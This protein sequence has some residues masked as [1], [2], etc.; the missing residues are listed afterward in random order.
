M[1]NKSST[2]LLSLALIIAISITGALN[3]AL[4]AD[5][6][7]LLKPSISPDVLDNKIKEVEAST[8]LDTS[9]KE[10]LTE[11]YR[12]SLTNLE[13]TRSHQAD[14]DSFSR[15]RENAP[16]ETA[17]LRAVLKEKEKISP[18]KTL[19]ISKNVT[20]EE[21]EQLLQK[22]KA[23]FAAVEAKL[24]DLNK[25]L[26]AQTNRP[27]K[28]RE[29]LIA[30]KRQQEN[31]ITEAKM[32]APEGEAPDV[33][34]ARRW[35]L[36]TQA[37][38]LSAEITMLDRELLS[39]QV[40]L[41]L[42]EVQRE[43]SEQDMRLIQ[44]R[45]R[46]LE[47]MLSQRRLA[48]AR[49]V[50]LE[51]ETLQ[52]KLKGKH[53]LISDLAQKN[54][55]LGESLRVRALELDQVLAQDDKARKDAKRIGDE[56]NTTR[57]KLE[58][59]G[60]NQVLGR[61]LMEQRRAL[62]NLG[63]MRREAGQRERLI[64]NAGLRQIQY[65]EERRQLRDIDAF[66]S[67]LVKP[68]DQ[69][70]ANAIHG[71]LSQLAKIRRELLDKAISTEASYL[72]SLGELD[73]AQRQLIDIIAKYDSY[74]GKRLLWIR[75]TESVNASMFSSLPQEIARLLSPS[76]WLESASILLKQLTSNPLA[77]LLALALA[78]LSLMRKRFLQAILASGKLVGRIRTDRLSF[79]FQTLFWT[80]LASAPLPLLLLVAGW[81]L[82]MALDATEFAKA[83]A[84]TLLRLAPEYLILQFLIDAGISGG[85]LT[86]HFRWP[87]HAVAKL[88]REYTLFAF[89]FL[90]SAFIA[91]HNLTLDR[92]YRA[93][94]DS[95]LGML[96]VVIAI[97]SIAIF[98]FRAFTPHGG[99]LSEYFTEH[100]DSLFARFHKVLLGLMLALITGLIAM[101]LVGYLYTGGTLTSNLINTIWLVNFLIL[102]RALAVRWLLIIR[103]R[104][105][106]QAA[107]ERREEARAA[108]EAAA[109]K[110]DQYVPASNEDT[111]DIEEP[112]V[113]LKALDADSRKLLDSVV[114]FTTLIGLW[115]IWSPVLPAFGILED[116]SVWTKT[117]TVEGVETTLPVT[118]A[119][120]MLALIIGIVTAVAARGLPAFLEFVL[121]Q[122]ISI[123]AGSRYT[124]TT[125]LRY[126]VVGVGTVIFFKTLGGS[127]SQIQWLVAALGVGIGFGLQ[128]IVA[129]FISGLIILFERPIRVG[130]VVTVGDTSGVVSRIQIRA[131][132]ITN[133]DRQELLVP[134]KEFITNRLLNWSLSDPII[135]IRI[136]VGIAYGSDVAK[137]M[138]LMKEAADEHS[139]VLADPA[140]SVTF[141]S[142]GDNSLGLFLLAF[143]PSMENRIRTITELHQ[144]INDKFNAAGIVISF[145]QRD[146]HLD[147][148]QPIDI[149]LHQGDTE[150]L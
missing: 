36:E 7:V 13:K 14:A 48:E 18:E 61:L 12:K 39:H 122:R 59:A 124:A 128:E 47:D 26:E 137:A 135:R 93:S 68:L 21:I 106:L 80:I 120:L 115:L 125:L 60:L 29:R 40:R 112:V 20:L 49:E 102:A 108:R 118:L 129:N 34:K 53:A 92:L 15:A 117:A 146:V 42:L 55:E 85:L 16:A 1:Q 133:W 96:A 43:V 67:G 58:I 145:P 97:G 79:T 110:D 107:L 66:I 86:K 8:T 72:R 69:A 89:L 9:T 50:Q 88:R 127:W 30:A 101:V 147:T 6:P 144:A 138:I 35:T 37:F 103:R 83:L 131:T 64:A 73:L 52:E 25:R 98:I 130:D 150:H 28:A 38:A 143:L 87:A 90:S 94:M 75:S 3:P 4:A 148:T 116:I 11:L 56:L 149:R 134:N 132:T 78:I 57:Q 140:P 119:D 45:I 24:S 139:N 27:G 74:L 81:Q 121:L 111:I 51:T 77:L 44:A 91:V 31:I 99:V 95:T 23:D 63:I 114:L 109:A 46:L 142:F 100:P 105:D 62:P 10:K 54:V 5:D 33:T 65:G 71:E 22:E 2:G 136:P 84:A 104:L 82:S 19:K 17:K 113:D 126:A 41:Q 76:S 141:E 70:E 32:T 123:T